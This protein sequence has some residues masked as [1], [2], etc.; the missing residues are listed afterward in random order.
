MTFFSLGAFNTALYNLPGGKGACFL[1]Y[2]C[3]P[4]STLSSLQ[5]GISLFL[6]ICTRQSLAAL[7]HRSPSLNAQYLRMQI[8]FDFKLKFLPYKITTLNPEFGLYS[9]TIFQDPSCHVS[10]PEPP[11]GVTSFCFCFSKSTN[12]LSM[13]ITTLQASLLVLHNYLC[14]ILTVGWCYRES[15]SHL[16]VNSDFMRKIHQPRYLMMR[17]HCIPICSGTH[18]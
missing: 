16:C 6:K 17:V 9:T 14:L 7:L 18:L 10:S 13:P 2:N 1:N 8:P 12:Y 5:I 4:V 11:N 3:I 15:R